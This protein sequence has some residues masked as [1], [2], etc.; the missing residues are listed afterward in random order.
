M[1]LY[2]AES[3]AGAHPAVKAPRGCHP[4]IRRT[5]GFKLPNCNQTGLSSMISEGSRKMGFSNEA[6]PLTADE[7]RTPPRECWHTAGRIRF[8][9]IVSESIQLW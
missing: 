6:G 4:L 3:D 8:G 9:L 2:G 1:A 5:P 7:H